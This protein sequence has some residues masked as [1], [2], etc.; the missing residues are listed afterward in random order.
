MLSWGF[1][2]Y[3]VAKCSTEIN[4]FVSGSDSGHGRDSAAKF[5]A[6]TPSS[7]NCCS[8][9]C[10]CCICGAPAVGQSSWGNG[11]FSRS[12]SSEQTKI[13]KLCDSF[14]FC[15]TSRSSHSGSR[16]W[17]RWRCLETLT[18]GLKMTWRDVRLTGGGNRGGY[19][20][21]DYGSSSRQQAGRLA[22][23]WTDPLRHFLTR[24]TSTIYVWLAD[25][26][27]MMSGLAAEETPTLADLA[28]HPFCFSDVVEA[29]T[30][31]GSRRVGWVSSTSSA[32]IGANEAAATEALS[33][34][35]RKWRLIS[36]RGDACQWG[37]NAVARRGRRKT[38]FAWMEVSCSF[39][40]K[41][42]AT[43]QKLFSE[44]QERFWLRPL[45]H[46]RGQD[47]NLLIHF[48]VTHLSSKWV[49]NVTAVDVARTDWYLSYNNIWGGDQHK[50]KI[51]SLYCA[52]KCT[53]FN[54]IQ[55]KIKK[56]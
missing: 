26:S 43:E 49:T 14:M 19:L 32:P 1:S 3:E 46:H 9:R 16:L 25:E 45:L 6:N 13:M 12:H 7:Y 27:G 22:L 33:T 18:C 24:L 10:C 42:I 2:L 34:C 55:W 47:L 17:R 20:L 36:F 8:R 4:H 31:A 5:V 39:L 48:L 37:I 44:R 15:P 54:I 29:A 40:R 50:Y 41:K 52:I 56:M 23:H 28:P 30:R 11:T 21:V 38:L 51:N 35:A 53:I